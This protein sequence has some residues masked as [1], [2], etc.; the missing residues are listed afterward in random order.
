MCLK[1]SCRPPDEGK[2]VRDE[3]DVIRPEHDKKVTHES[4][5]SFWLSMSLTTASTTSKS[6]DQR[7]ER[8]ASSAGRHVGRRCTPSGKGQTEA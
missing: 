4:A 6:V 1:I 2:G 5:L 3:E 8:R 7:R